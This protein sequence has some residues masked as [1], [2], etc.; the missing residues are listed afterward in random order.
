MHK[1]TA[2]RSTNGQGRASRGATWR[3]MGKKATEEAAVER[4]RER[5]QDGV[6]AQ[7]APFCF[8]ASSARCPPH[9]LVSRERL[10]IAGARGRHGGV[11]IVPQVERG[12]AQGRGRENGIPQGRQKHEHGV[13]AR[14]GRLLISAPAADLTMPTFMQRPGHLSPLSASDRFQG[15]CRGNGLVGDGMETRNK[16]PAAVQSKL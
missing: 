4:P 12:T 5:P 1:K 14:P 3:A 9:V 6:T 13:S 7:H 15:L 10:D 16:A 2:T 8:Q 11:F